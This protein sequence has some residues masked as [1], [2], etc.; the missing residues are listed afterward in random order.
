M[1]PEEK[2]YFFYWKFLKLIIFSL[3]CLYKYQIDG[4]FHYFIAPPPS[5]LS[6]LSIWNNFNRKFKAITLNVQ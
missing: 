1:N 2:M 5:S 4:H 3:K 6:L